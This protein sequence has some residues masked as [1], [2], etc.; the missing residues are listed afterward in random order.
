[1]NQPDSGFY[2]QLEQT[3]TAFAQSRED[4][5]AAFLIGSRARTDHPADQ[6]SDMDIVFYTTDPDH[7]LRHREW[8]DSLGEVLCSFVAPTAGGDPERLNLFEG[9]YQVDFVIHSADTLRRMAAK[10]KIPD[11]FCRG[12][13]VLVDKENLSE[14]LLPQ[15]FGAPAAP[16]ISQEAFSQV[17]TMFWFAVLHMAKQL[18]RG[19]LWVAKMRDFDAK[20]LLLQM[21]EWHEK[22]K[23]GSGYDTWHAGRFLSQWAD[24]D[25]Q[26]DLGKTF[27]RYDPAD[28]WDALLATMELFQRLSQEVASTAGYSRAQGLEEFVLQWVAARPGE[29]E[30]PAQRG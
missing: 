23:F 14:Y 29:R 21:L 18:L 26:A 15:Q 2:S 16:P 24:E 12:V 7:Y 11:N 6:W 5:R 20:R 25:I 3:F 30:Q 8:V 17:E 10:K 1:M 9:G 13:R 28:S 19:E 22:A 27:G 4:I